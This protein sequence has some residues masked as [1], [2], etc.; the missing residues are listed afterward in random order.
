MNATKLQTIRPAL[1]VCVAVAA[2]LSACT[3]YIEQPRSDYQ[4]PP[5]EVYVPPPAPVEVEVAIRSEND[6]YEPLRPYGR[7]ENVGPYGR[8]WVPARVEADWRPYCNG[9]W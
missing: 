5:R 7:W 6:F 8:C 1:F 4:P 9:H 2:T 3:T